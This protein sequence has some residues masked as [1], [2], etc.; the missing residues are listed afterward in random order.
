MK[1]I[2]P[3]LISKLKN[4]IV[5]ILPEIT[6]LRHK[7]HQYPEVGLETYKSSEI[8]KDFLKTLSLDYKKPLLGAD[9]I[10]ELKANQSKTICLRAD[11]DALPLEE[12]N[13]LLYKSLIPGKMHACGHD[14]HSAVLAGTALVLDS[15][16]EY[17]PVNVRYVFQ[18]GEE[19]YGGGKIMVAKGV[20][21]GCY[22]AYA[23][24][25]NPG[26]QI[27]T[28]SSKEGLMYA[29]GSFF[30]ITIKGKGCHGAH[31]EKGLNPIPSASYIVDKI[32]KLHHKLA[33]NGS[34]ISVCSFEAGTNSNVIPDNAIIRGTARYIGVDL[35]DEIESEIRKIVSDITREEGLQFDII[36]DRSYDLPVINSKEGYNLVKNI[37]KNYLPETYWF[38]EEN[39]TTGL[40]DFAFYLKDREGALFWL[41]MGENSSALHASTFDFNDDALYY[42]ILAMSLIALSQ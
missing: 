34:V 22:S 5:K 9:I 20:C 15:L 17:L 16:K 14:G 6:N 11:M 23:L 30:T 4:K 13:D 21:D 35:G 18:P 28:I 2:T 12:K 33:A 1:E 32:Y 7:L 25:S 29:A 19:L 10:A 3:E 39:H 37:A 38:K 40:E 31:P 36:Y 24:H 26:I 8:I 42:G 41:G 27:G